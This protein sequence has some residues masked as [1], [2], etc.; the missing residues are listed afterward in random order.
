MRT[1]YIFQI[2]REMVALT[3]ELP[4]NLYKTLEE[5]YLL[6]KSKISY[7]KDIMDQLIIPLNKENYNK[8][9]YQINK[10]NDFYMKIGD[11]HSIYNKY[12]DEKTTITIKKSHIILQTNSLIKNIKNFL[13][14]NNLFVCDF[15]NK[16]Y[17][18]L[19]KLIKL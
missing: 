13:P 11:V 9:I 19:S 18:W 3:E 5:I 8:A 14:T 2:K 15:T 12:R 16:D 4:Y 17:V 6:D 10:D 1:F 7:G